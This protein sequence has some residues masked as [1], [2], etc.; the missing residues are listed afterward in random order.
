[1]IL[2]K[3]IFFMRNIASALLNL[4]IWCLEIIRRVLPAYAPTDLTPTGKDSNILKGEIL[5]YK[6]DRQCT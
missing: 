5:V 6:V 1:M 3:N 4:L 2:L